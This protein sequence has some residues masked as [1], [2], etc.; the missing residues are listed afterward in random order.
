VEEY[1]DQA[2]TLG[3]DS[4]GLSYEEVGMRASLICRFTGSDRS[5]EQ[6]Q[7]LKQHTHSK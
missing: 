6:L 3:V 1:R 2:V 5:M 4:R 7:D